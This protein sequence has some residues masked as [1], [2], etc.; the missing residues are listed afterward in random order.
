[1][2][3]SRSCERSSR[4]QPGSEARQTRRYTGPALRRRGGAVIV[5]CH[6]HVCATTPGHGTVS[7]RLRRRFSFVFMRWRLGISFFGGDEVIE[8]DVE[9]RLVDTVQQTPEIDAAVVLALDDPYTDDGRPD[10]VN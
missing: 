2:R 8:R 4:K 1:M 3:R 6:V 7:R 5:D 9:A 10:E